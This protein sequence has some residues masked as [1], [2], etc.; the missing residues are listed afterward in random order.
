MLHDVIGRTPAVHRACIFM[1]WGSKSRVVVVT[2]PAVFGS[3]RFIFSFSF[4]KLLWSMFQVHAYF[5]CSL[6]TILRRILDYLTRIF[7]DIT[8]LMFWMGLQ[9][10]FRSL[11]DT[12]HL[13]ECSS[14]DL[15]VPNPTPSRY[16]R[17]F[18]LSESASAGEEVLTSV[19]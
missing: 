13:L 1:C 12:S 18:I 6:L 15:E 14:R 16:G 19:Y 10:H 2:F 9:Q 5:N 8:H 17:T 3:K 4:L 11:L 7:T